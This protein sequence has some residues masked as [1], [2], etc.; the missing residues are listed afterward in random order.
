[1]ALTGQAKTEYQKLYMRRRRAG[2]GKPPKAEREPTMQELFTVRHLARCQHG[3]RFYS[4]CMNRLLIGLEKN[5]PDFELQAVRRVREHR[6][7]LRAKAN[8]K[9]K[10]STIDRAA[11]DA[12]IDARLNG[13]EFSVWP[14]KWHQCMFCDN[15]SE[16]HKMAGTE[17][18]FICRE[19]A[20]K[21]VNL[22]E[23]NQPPP[24]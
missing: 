4:T 11:L 24:D 21:A 14:R 7:E 23:S 13:R 19:C 1:M 9:K 12:R 2:L 5:A 17:Y 10:V 22:M 15:T 20:R 3:A 6:A 16:K 8:E 18:A